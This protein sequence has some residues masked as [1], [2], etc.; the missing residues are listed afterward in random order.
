[1]NLLEIKRDFELAAKAKDSEKAKKV[2]QIAFADTTWR[3]FE[4]SSLA[5]SIYLCRSQS[6]FLNAMEEII[7]RFPASV[8]PMQ[9][10]FSVCLSETGNEDRATVEARFYLSRLNEFRK[11]G[12]AEANGHPLL[13]HGA[14]LALPVLTA[15]YTLAGARSY[16]LRVFEHGIK[17]FA[18]LSSN[19]VEFI[20]SLEELLKKELKAPENVSLDK[21]W[22]EFF[23]SGAHY[24]ELDDLCLSKNLALLAD[25]ISLLE[26]SFRFNAPIPF[27]KEV[28]KNVLYLTEKD[29]KVLKTLA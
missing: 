12:D 23:K 6:L 14:G 19:H 28:F 1:M 4:Y 24:T 13:Q 21:K 2:L 11:K 27:E 18:P 22:E 29:G 17:A 3:A 7:R 10:M 8:L 9:A 16:C 25:R 15:S 20:H 26:S 5:E